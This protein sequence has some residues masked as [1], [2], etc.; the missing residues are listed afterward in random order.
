MSQCEICIYYEIRRTTFE[1]AEKRW[2][3][4]P[5][6]G[7]MYMYILILISTRKLVLCLYMY[8]KLLSFINSINIFTRMPLKLI[9]RM[10]IRTQCGKD[11]DA[12]INE[13]GICVTDGSN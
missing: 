7:S 11:D 1:K 12:E 3:I 10:I 8:K 2:A 9:E 4:A 5:G 6:S 13:S